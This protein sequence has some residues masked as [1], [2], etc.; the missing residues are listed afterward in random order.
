MK[1]AHLFMVAL[2][3][4][5]VSPATATAN[6]ERAAAEPYPL[7]YFALREV[8][9]SVQVSP[10]GKRVA[11]LK[12]P[13]RDGD[14]ILEIYETGDLQA[15]P[16]RLNADP[17]EITSYNWVSNK[18]IVFSVRQKVRDKIEGFNQGV[19]ENRVA[20]L[21]VDKKEYE[22]FKETGGSISSLL[23]NE[24]NK[25]IISFLPG[26]KKSFVKEAFRPRAYYEYDLRTG[27]R[28]LV[29]RG[30][31][32]MAQIVFDGNGHPYT[33][34][35]FD[36]GKGEYVW[37]YRAPG[38]RKWQEIYRMSEDSYEEFFVEG[39]DDAKP[40]NLLVSAQNGHDKIGLWS[41]NTETN[42]FEELI[43]RRSDVDVA[44]VD[45]H[46]NSWRYP[47][48]VVGVAY[49]KDRYRTE[50]FDEE[51]GAIHKQ[52]EDLIPYAHGPSITSRSVDGQV[53]IVYNSGPRDPG[54]YYLYKDG[55][56]QT[57]GSKQPLLA[58]ERLADVRYFTFKARDGREVAAYATIPN[59][60]PPF[61]T[62]V[63]PHGGP[64]VGEVVGYD[65]W[66]QML[67]NNGYL[68]IQPQY[69]GSL[70]YGLDHH[71][72]AFIDGSEAGFAMQD[73][74]DDSA[75]HMV[76]E[77]LADPDRLAMFGWSYGGYAALAAAS[78]TPQIY[79][80]AIAGAAVADMTMQLNYYRDEL[81]GS[82]RESQLKYRTGAL[83]PIDNVD[84]VNIPMLLIHGDV[85]QR[86]PPEHMRRYLKKL[87]DTDK[88]YRAV[89]LEGADHFYSTL[90]YDHQITLY[91]NLVGYLGDECGPDGLKAD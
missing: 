45:M 63:M 37:F 65:E 77:G 20:W 88:S 76:K 21:D 1:L 14:P 11:L 90:F 28:K 51:E 39:Y 53:F 34:R 38:T 73:D 78:R 64:F 22:L 33:A 55:Q 50:Y 15:D 57:I 48:K 32:D 19:Y 62:V 81:R 41:F 86:V 59:G 8:I 70:G 84:D 58:G 16:F 18:D 6:E 2:L 27:N 46:S 75:L 29:L 80:C 25:I 47:D 13:S 26:G 42:A 52:L 87:E 74:K 7:E 56:F 35:G 60:K 31:I 61:P 91:E 83:N 68:V 17:M 9:R 69:R 85:D 54:T 43:Y 40:G 71:L 72:S 23:P 10:D 30:K 49:G 4:W 79:Q 24:P 82:Q 12:I 89:W 44:G 5:V 66:G 67:A 3:L 36:L